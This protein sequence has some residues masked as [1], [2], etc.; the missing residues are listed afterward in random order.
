MV[1]NF[2]IIGAARSGTSTLYRY[3]QSHPEIYLRPNKRPELHFFFKA[4]EYVKGFRYYEET[5]FPSSGNWRAVGEA[6][7]SYL[8]GPDV[9]ARIARDLPDVLLIAVLRNPIDRA[10]SNYWHSVRSGVET[11]DFGMAIAQETERTKAIEGTHLGEL[12][13]YSYVARGLYHTQITNFLRFFDRS[14]LAIFTFEELCETP[15]LL[16]KE[17]YRRLGIASECL[18]PRLDIVENRS[19]PDGAKMD[20]AVRRRLVDVY[21][22]DVQSLSKLLDRDFTAWLK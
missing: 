5:W 4:A 1:P 19:V 9:P 6:S 2:L 8:F 17:I 11:L 21:S 18:P 13:P 22:E 3:L 20:P 15:S 10:F 12:K 14:Q 16:L 7:T